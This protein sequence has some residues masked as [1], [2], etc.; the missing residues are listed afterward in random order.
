MRGKYSYFN[1]YPDTES[2]SYYDYDYLI[3]ILLIGDSGVGKSSMAQ[4]FVD[5][6]ISSNPFSTIGVDFVVRKQILTNNKIAKLQIW[7][8]AGQERFRSII[9]SYYRGAHGIIMVYD[10]TNLK[11]LENCFDIWMRDI[12]KYTVTEKDPIIVLFGNKADLN[13]KN[14]NDIIQD[15]AEEFCKHHSILHLRGS[16]MIGMGVDNIFLSVVELVIS[17]R[18]SPEL[19][20]VPRDYIPPLRK[21]INTKK[22]INILDNFI[23]R[24]FS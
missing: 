9:S 20:S 7:D 21:C 23:S 12:K 2:D 13:C 22:K 5:D 19:L 18:W 1:P 8:T 17:N 3:K 10:A 11:S 14:D 15:K 16:A 6:A 24:C 4:R